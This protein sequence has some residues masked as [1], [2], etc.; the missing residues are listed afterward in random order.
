MA[1][2]AYY[3]GSGVG[4]WGLSMRQYLA[5][6]VAVA[7]VSLGSSSAT[8]AADIPV[9]ARPAPVSIAYNWTGFYVGGHVG[10]GW[11]RSTW[12]DVNGL[13]VDDN[14][15]HNLSGALAG[16]QAG[17]NHQSGMWVFGVE[18]DIAWSG[19]K[20]SSF[21]DAV[22]PVETRIRWLST[23]TG[24]VGL[25][26]GAWL[27]YVKGGAVVVDERV[28]ISLPLAAGAPTTVTSATRW[29]WT[30]GAGVEHGFAPNWTA[31]LEYGYV[32]LGTARAQSAF[33]GF[34][35]DVRHHVH[36]AKAALNYRIGR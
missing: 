28:T 25:A 11:G 19:I 7:G 2:T 14:T 16:L 29:G 18:A 21:F 8:Q 20:G 31:R 3:C 13:V 6:L 24:R 12:T 4:V 5:A 26:H 1:G 33:A 15:S 35:L 22:D 34:P 32:D 36:V 9:K 27:P 23:F 30:L 10:Y 17:Y